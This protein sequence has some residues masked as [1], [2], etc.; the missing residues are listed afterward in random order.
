MDRMPDGV[1]QDLLTEGFDRLVQGL[2]LRT[3]AAR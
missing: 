3:H 2:A 1:D